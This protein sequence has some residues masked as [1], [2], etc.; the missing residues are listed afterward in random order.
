MHERT[1]VNVGVVGCGRMGCAIA[2]EFVR[3]GCTVFLY[4]HTEY[5]RTR[6]FQTLRAFLWDHVC[7]A[8]PSLFPSL[9]PNPPSPCFPLPFPSLSLSS[10]PPPRLPSSHLS[11]PFPRTSL[12][13]AILPPPCSSL[14]SF[15]LPSAF[16]PLVVCFR[17]PTQP[18]HLPTA[19]L[20]A[21][22][23]VPRLP[24]VASGYL[25]KPD[26]EELMGRIS[27]C[28]TLAETLIK[29]EVC[30]CTRN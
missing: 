22:A 11:L 8:L 23:A 20:V 25:L 4:D 24:K 13:P 17:F 28:D 10:A 2:G 3:R 12:P 21:L 15:P 1:D 16:I 29:S 19:P 6:A 14:P 27:V 18:T 26:V 5:T 30:A 7:L 9:F